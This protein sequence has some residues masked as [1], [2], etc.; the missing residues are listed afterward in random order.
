MSAA[1]LRPDRAHPSVTRA[2]EQLL[3]ACGG[4]LPGPVADAIELAERGHRGQTRRSG[5]PYLIHPLMTGAILAQGGWDPT[6]IAAGICHDL[7]ED[8]TVSPSELRGVIGPDAAYLVEGVTRLDRVRTN[9]SAAEADDL[10]RLLGAVAG[11]VRVLAVKLADRLHNVR[12]LEHLPPDKR[13]RIARQTLDIFAPL[14]H[15][16]GA[17]AWARE[18]EDR[19]FKWADPEA[20]E[21]A[22]AELEAVTP[23]REELEARVSVQ[24]RQALEESG[25]RSDVSSRAKGYWSLWRKLERMGSMNEIWDLVGLRVVVDDIA[26]CYS[27]LGVVHAQFVPVPGRFKDYI[28]L[29]KPNGYRSLHT[30]VIDGTGRHFEVQI[31]DRSMDLDARYGAA[32]HF[33]YKTGD[34][35]G[36]KVEVGSDLGPEEFLDAL[37]EELQ[38]GGQVLTLTPGGDVIA[39]PHGSCA[40]DFAYA[41]HTDVGHRCV[42]A[43]VNG[44]LVPIRSR[45][46][47]GDTIE[48]LTKPEPGPSRDWLEAVASPSARAKIRRWFSHQDRDELEREGRRILE[49]AE[50]D[51]LVKLDHMTLARK[52]KLDTTQELYRRLGSG[53]IVLR[54]LLEGPAPARP[55][56]V[57]QRRAP[58]LDGLRSEAARCCNPTADDELVGYVSAGRGLV[59]HRA[60]CRNLIDLRSRM[61]GEHSGRFLE[62]GRPS[63]T[64][65]VEVIAGDREGL[66][67]EV[68]STFT[69]SG[70]NITSARTQTH[71]H[72]VTQHISIDRVDSELLDVLLERLCELP[73]VV[74]ARVAHQSGCT[75]AQCKPQRRWR[76]RR[77]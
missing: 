72:R 17:I 5:E 19:S 59:L 36:P 2:M 45:L 74:S 7:L 1:A 27:A 66:L 28:A 10:Q 13:Q 3:N 61:G 26:S 23:D 29:P 68:A 4:T 11:D 40:I 12:T 20:Y 76:P 60:D 44:R 62:L 38:A 6:T 53:R 70:I 75:C 57:P 49:R 9:R 73:S 34:T 54:N 67:S 15:R 77:G 37:R 22:R 48:I 8:T 63:D 39:L 47:T 33:R 46:S 64:T 32:A 30:T 43:R 18:L 69:S 50:V 52:A 41:V 14:A 51:G 42:G 31:R 35:A 24:L 65:V 55:S 71:R 16:L 21:L 56:P 25:V 58:D